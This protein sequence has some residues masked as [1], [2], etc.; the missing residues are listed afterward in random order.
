ASARCVCGV[1]PCWMKRRYFISLPPPMECGRALDERRARERT[2]VR[3]SPS[4]RPSRVPPLLGDEHDAD[5]VRV[6]EGHTVRRP[7]RVC[8]LKGSRTDACARR[9]NCRVT[10]EVDEETRLRGG[11]PRV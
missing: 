11:P 10:G 1:S 8:R 6:G 4:E 3:M 7:V 9:G 2:P 5:P